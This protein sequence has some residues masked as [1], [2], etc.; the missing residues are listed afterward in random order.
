M[1]Q[2]NFEYLDSNYTTTKMVKNNKQ[3]WNQMNQKDFFVSD[4]LEMSPIASQ[5]EENG[6]WASDFLWIWNTV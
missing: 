3:Q 1:F 2:L 5:I 6:K 4:T